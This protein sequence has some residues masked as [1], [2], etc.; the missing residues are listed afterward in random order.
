MGNEILTIGGLSIYLKMIEKHFT[1][2]PYQRKFQT[3]RLM[4]FG[5]VIIIKINKQIGEQ[6]Y[7]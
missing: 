5:I 6:K 4:I 1:D 7:K 2:Q 3:L